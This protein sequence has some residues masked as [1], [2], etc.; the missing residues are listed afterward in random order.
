MGFF[1]AILEFLRDFFA[2]LFFANSPKTIRRKKLKNILNQLRS[3]SRPLMTKELFVLPDFAKIIFSI[4]VEALPIKSILEQTIMNEDIRIANRFKDLL[5]SE[6]FSSEQKKEFQLFSYKSRQ[7]EI[8]KEANASIEFIQRRLKDQSK[9]FH[10]FL[11][12]LRTAELIAIE[13]SIQ[14]LYSLYDFCSF[15]YYELLSPFMNISPERFDEIVRDGSTAN[16]KK[17]MIS[18]IM[19]ELLDFHFVF[20]NVNIDKDLL[21][22]VEIIHKKLTSRSENKFLFVMQQISSLQDIIKKDLPGNTIL[23]MIRYAKG[24]PDYDDK[25]QATQAHILDDFIERL[26]AQ[27]S[28]D[29]KK[30]LLLFQESQIDALVEKTFGDK[31]LYTFAGYNT[32]VNEHLQKSTSLS[33]DWIR[34]MDLLRTFT[35]QNFEIAMKNLIKTVLVEGFFI[36][37]SFQNSLG[38]AF[39]YCEGLSDKFEDFERLFTAGEKCSLDEINAYLAEIDNGG[40]FEKPLAKIVDEANVIAKNI[41]QSSVEQYTALFSTCSQ[42]LAD[43]KRHNS[44]LVSNIKVLFNSSKLRGSV[45]VFER[46]LQV[47]EQ[48]LEIMKN[49]AILLRMDIS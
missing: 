4:Y 28:S 47:L 3:L 24:D 22:T 11:H 2:S 5:I 49:Y 27:F 38:A 7:A 26:E 15:N 12:S 32:T 21:N 44:E 48:F 6:A 19:K 23:N 29:L 14:D 43:S 34:P 37:N 1:I 42:L 45:S 46:E 8:Q 18:D 10:K 13:H 30:L 16:F 39:Y 41:V 20:K 17:I 31:K 36:D 25:T 9:R 40:N 33:F 35:K